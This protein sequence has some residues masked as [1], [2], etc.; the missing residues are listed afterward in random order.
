MVVVIQFSL[1]FLAEKSELARYKINLLG[2]GY[3]NEKDESDL[4]QT[5]LG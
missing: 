1:I 4:N 2:G 3:Q 5:A